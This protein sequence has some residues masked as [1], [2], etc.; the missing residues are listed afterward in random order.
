M[1]PTVHHVE[2]ITDIY[3]DATGKLSVE[4]DVA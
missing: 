1:A 4:E 2:D 3:T